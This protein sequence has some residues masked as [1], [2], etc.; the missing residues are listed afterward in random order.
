[1]SRFDEIL[2]EIRSSH[3]PPSKHESSKYRKIVKN[4]WKVLHRPSNNPHIFR[5][6][7]FRIMLPGM[8]LAILYHS[9]ILMNTT[10]VILLEGRSI[11]SL[12]NG[13]LRYTPHKLI[14]QSLYN[15]L[16]NPSKNLHI[17][18]TLKLPRRQLGPY[19]IVILP[20]QWRRN[21]PNS[22]PLM[23]DLEMACL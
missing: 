18:W 16:R 5:T 1:M 22:Q 12:Q 11:H 10:K 4:H 21:S 13:L 17:L 2:P 8:S 15:I 3:N 19:P 6:P 14:K 23:M 20:T 7:L 9:L